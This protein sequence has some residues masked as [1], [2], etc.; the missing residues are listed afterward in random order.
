MKF[1]LDT[2]IIIPVEPT[3]SD[4]LEVNTVIIASLIQ[5]FQNGG[6]QYFVHQASLNELK[7]DSDIQRRNTRSRLLG[8]YPVLK[9]SMDIQPD[10]SIAYSDVKPNSHNITDQILLSALVSEAVDYFVTDD[11]GIHAKASQLGIA[12]RVAT[13]EDALSIIQALFPTEPRKIPALKS[14]FAYELDAKDPI[15]ESF[16]KDYPDFD[17]WLSKCKREHRPVLTINVGDS[18]L[19]GVC[20]LKKEDI[21]DYDLPLPTLKICSFKVNEESRGL[22][23]GELLLK[24]LFE[25]VT[26]KE[27]RTIYLETFEKQA[28]LIN[29]LTNFG[30]E[31]L[32][33]RS[34]KGELVLWKRLFFT[35][36]EVQRTDPLEFNIR[37]G[38]R[39][40]KMDNVGM[41]I[42]P[43]IPKYHTMLFP[44]FEEQLDIFP[45]QNPF[46]NGIRKAYLCRANIRSI[47][48][49]DVV[50]FYRS[51][52][53]QALTVYGVVEEITVSNI[54]EEIARAVG[55]RTVYK[56]DEIQEMCSS[57]V[58][59]ISFRFCSMVDIPIKMKD[60][61]SNNVLKAPPQSIVSAN[62]EGV[63]WLKQQ[64]K[65]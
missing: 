6:H 22:R 20:I 19:Q 4:G 18:Q 37:F 1:L 50:T 16:R 33:S 60:L 26:H 34:Q 24:G 9:I 8:K 12:S 53:L 65:K 5:A 55:K 41:F 31:V 48:P 59:A 13:S 43:I 45:G 49:G 39:S 27:F 52:D 25:Y 54:P 28:A 14:I 36:D 32:E 51:H 29:L 42:V 58:L 46:G 7:R 3:A 57:E 15:F 2:N 10:V 35:N 61:I 38:P 44:D 40:L 17:D 47:F 64:L 11:L 23:Y 63:K 62:Q 30:F 56:F 21:C